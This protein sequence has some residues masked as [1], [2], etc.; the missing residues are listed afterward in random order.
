MNSKSIGTSTDRQP[1]G[2]RDPRSV[3]DFGLV[4]A[5]L[6]DYEEMVLALAHPLLQVYTI[7]KTGQLAYVGHPPTQVQVHAHAITKHA[8][9]I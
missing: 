8:F 9:I 6:T 2:I 4:V 5:A 1:H 3:Q 7:P